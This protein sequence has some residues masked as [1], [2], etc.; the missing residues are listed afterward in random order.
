MGI[1]EYDRDQDRSKDGEEKETEP[2][3]P[4]SPEFLM[5]CL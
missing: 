4:A 5:I 3:A 2:A 1:A